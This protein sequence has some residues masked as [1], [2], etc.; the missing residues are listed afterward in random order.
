M[1]ESSSDWNAAIDAY[2]AVTPDHARDADEMVA[3]WESAVRVAATHERRRYLAVAGDVGRRL[4]AL[5]RWGPAAELLREAEAWKEAIDA[6]TKDNQWDKARELAKSAAPTLRDSVERDY[7]AHLKAEGDA[8]GMA[9]TGATDAAL[10]LFAAQGKWDKVFETAAKAGAATLAKYA[11]PFAKT[12]LDLGKPADVVQF[13]ARYGAPGVAAQLPLY[14]RLVQALFAGP[15]ATAVKDDVVVEARDVMYK[16]VSALRRPG[17]EVTPLQMQEFEKLLLAL[18]YAA[19]RVKAVELG[20]DD[21]ALRLSLALLRFIGIVP[22]DR[23]FLDAGVAA[24]KRGALSL[25]FVMLNRYLDLSEA[26]D[27]GDAAGVDNTDFVGTDVPPPSEFPLPRVHW[28]P[29]ER[30]DEVRD[31]VLTISMDRKVEQALPAGALPTL[32]QDTLP[33]CVVTG[34]PVTGTDMC[35]CTACGSPATKV[36]WNAVVT[37][38]RA[39][40][41]CGAAQSPAF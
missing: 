40:P 37:K 18:H 26:V 30:R 34:F 12:Q 31:W 1:W 17:A 4:A 41:W 20:L 35:T 28:L 8:E 33:R 22:A 23:A 25:A 14:Q 13:F 10:E 39:C 24:R 38:T 16:V 11:F 36:H 27:E 9:R 7:R 5:R 21:V 19:L 32:D 3:A 6:Y 15:A 29:E 2:L